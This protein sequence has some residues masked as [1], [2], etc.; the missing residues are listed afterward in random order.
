[1]PNST[2]HIQ[3]VSP[4]PADNIPLACSADRAARMRVTSGPVEQS[5]AVDVSAADQTLT[6]PAR[7]V[8]CGGAGNMVCRLIGDSSDRTFTGLLAGSFY[9]LAVSIIRKTSTTI[10]NSVALL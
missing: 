2:V 6:V 10:T 9:P 3:Y 1:M 4:T 7:G 5:V 8:Y